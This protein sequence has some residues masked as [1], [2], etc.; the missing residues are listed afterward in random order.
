MLISYS[1]K[2]GASVSEAIFSDGWM[3]RSSSHYNYHDTWI[4]F[5]VF[6]NW[7]GKRGTLYSVVKILIIIY[8]IFSPIYLSL[9]F[10]I[11][12]YLNISLRLSLYHQL[13]FSTLKIVGSTDLQCVIPSVLA[14]D[15]LSLSLLIMCVFLSIFDVSQSKI[16]YTLL[17]WRLI[18]L[19]TTDTFFPQ[20]RHFTFIRRVQ[21]L[22]CSQCTHL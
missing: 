18:Q 6:G 5:W 9:F 1:E 10:P 20:N 22:W 21:W 4:W 8:R 17:T 19:F 16:N 2:L 12:F 15:S 13:I 3:C 11:N 14:E 7:R